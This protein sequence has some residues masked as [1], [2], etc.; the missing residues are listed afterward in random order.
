MT[1]P[2]SL[3]AF[4]C[5]VTGSGKSTLLRDLFIA[6]YP[7]TIIL[8]HTAEW[9]EPD[10][11][12]L[13]ELRRTLR[14]VAGRGYWRVVAALEPE[15]APELA[16]LLAP[17][18]VGR[19]SFAQA[20]GGVALAVDEVD[21]IAGRSCAPE[22]AALWRRGRHAGLS[23]FA[24]TQRPADVN[25]VV[26]SQ[27]QWLGLCR[28]HEPR[29]LAYLGSIIPADAL[30]ALEQLPEYGA[31][32]WETATRAGAVLDKDLRLVRRV[33]IQP[34]LPVPPAAPSRRAPARAGM[35]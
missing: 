34:A 7:R 23:I 22:V 6:R 20:V 21:V 17:R 11:L 29:D 2:P 8:A 14:K 9:G 5:G 18:V 27:S 24:A 15:D 30:R 33:G 19:P 28:T 26:T 25:R 10:A 1:P 12:S 31:L 13:P 3:R 16:E 4:V 35:T 32:L